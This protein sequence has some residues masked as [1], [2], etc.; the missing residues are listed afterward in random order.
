MEK[1]WWGERRGVKG[2]LGVRHVLRLTHEKGEAKGRRI[3][4]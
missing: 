1:K 4:S 2:K 3:A